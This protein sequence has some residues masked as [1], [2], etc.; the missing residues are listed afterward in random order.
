MKGK[1]GKK[2]KKQLKKKLESTQDNSTTR[3][4]N[5]KIIFF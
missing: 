5:E 4:P 3:N 2:K 1:T